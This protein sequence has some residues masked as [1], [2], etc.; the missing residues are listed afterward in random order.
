MKKGYGCKPINKGCGKWLIRWCAGYDGAGK[1]IMRRE[2]IQLDPKKTESAQ[3]AEA[4]R[5][6][7]KIALK[8]EEG[9]LTAAKGSTL[10]EYV[11][12]WQESYCVRKG[13]KDST[14]ADYRSMLDHRIIPQLGKIKLRDIHAEQLN[15]FL[16]GLQ[17]EG[18]SGTTQRRYFNLIHLIL[19][20]ATREQRIAVNPADNI[21]PPKKDTKE[22]PHFTPEQTALLVEALNAHAS[23]KWRAYALLALASAIRKGEEV[24][25]NWSDIDWQRRTVSIRRAAAYAK[26]KGQYLST[27]KTKSSIRTIKIDAESMEALA[28]WKREQ[29]ERRLLLGAMWQTDK[30]GAD[31]VFTQDMGGRMSIHSPTQWFDGFLKKHGLPAMN[32]HGLRHTAASLLLANGC[33][34]L[35]VSK[36][37]G[38][39]RASTTMD[40]YGHAYEEADEGLADVMGSVMYHAR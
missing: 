9:R 26:G 1:K 14:V 17:K 34:M 11:E 33:P 5:Y 19:G 25:L 29:N 16:I 27:P 12:E 15:K 3:L 30:E 36:R 28:A 23:T 37:L 8:M 13:L 6:R 24:G 40:I 35:D 7:D 38:H 2:T 4:I 31:A 22:R 10:K 39:S 20:T 32:L 21:E 18:L